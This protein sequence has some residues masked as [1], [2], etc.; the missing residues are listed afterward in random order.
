MLDAK[1]APWLHCHQDSWPGAVSGQ[2]HAQEPKEKQ[3]A[4]SP[5][6]SKTVSLLFFPMYDTASL[7]GGVLATT[8][9]QLP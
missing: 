4:L 7:R 1:A 8:I 3:Q 5:N 9:F 2:R 6:Q